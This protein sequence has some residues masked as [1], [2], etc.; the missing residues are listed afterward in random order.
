MEPRSEPN[1]EQPLIPAPVA[2]P[3]TTCKYCKKEISR[4]ASLSPAYCPYCGGIVNPD[5]A[6]VKP[7]KDSNPLTGRALWPLKWSLLAILIGMGLLMMASIIVPL[8]MIFAI[9]GANPSLISGD[10]T[11]LE[12]LVYEVL[13]NPVSTALLSATEFVLVIPP[14][15]IMRKYRKSVKERFMLLGWWPYTGDSGRGWGRLGRDLAWGL[16]IAMG[17]VGFQFIIVVLNDALW[18]PLIPSGNSGLSDL[19]AS[20]TPR[21]PFQLVL[22]VASMML[23]IGPTE[24]ILFRGFSQQGLEAR[25][26]PKH[27]L[28]I[29]ALLF[30]IVHVIGGFVDPTSLPFLFFPYFLLSLVLCG[31]YWRTKDLNL[32]IFVHGMYDSLLVVYSYIF[33]ELSKVGKEEFSDIFVYISFVALSVLVTYLTVTFIIHKRHQVGAIPLFRDA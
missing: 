7:E 31:I 14:F 11:A 29:S 6:P 1:S 22:L 32:M 2:T 28:V 21:D 33:S 24:E 25:L 13:L 12:D 10:L 15:A 26:D 18:S 9:I 4:F 3:A 19:D 16:L 20:I 5:L 23:V 17:L 27:A 30:T 8:L